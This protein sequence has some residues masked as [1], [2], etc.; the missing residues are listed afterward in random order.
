MKYNF[1]EE[2]ATNVGTFELINYKEVLKGALTGFCFF[3]PSFPA[4]IFYSD[5]CEQTE[6]SPY[7]S[8][9]FLSAHK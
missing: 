4:A 1:G 8:Y 6:P 9:V 2:A 7:N 5:A 3:F